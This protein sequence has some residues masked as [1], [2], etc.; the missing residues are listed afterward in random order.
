MLMNNDVIFSRCAQRWA[1]REPVLLTVS[2][3][4]VTFVRRLTCGC[5]STARTLVAPSYAPNF[6]YGLKE[7][8]RLTPLHS[9]RRNG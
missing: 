5:T 1:Q 9:I 7:L 2:T 8:R 3:K 6:A 4:L